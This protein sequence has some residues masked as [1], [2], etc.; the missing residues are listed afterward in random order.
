MT[1]EFISILVIV[2]VGCFLIILSIRNNRRIREEKEKEKE[3]S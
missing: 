2:F 1:K 3:L